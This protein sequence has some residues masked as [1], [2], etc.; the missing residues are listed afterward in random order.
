MTK[1][2]PKAFFDLETLEK[3]GIDPN[4]AAPVSSVT[5]NAHPKTENKERS[6]L[7][8]SKASLKQPLQENPNTEIINQKQAA[9]KKNKELLELLCKRFPRVFNLQ[10]PQPLKIN[11]VEDLCIQLKDEY[12]NEQ[13]RKAIGYYTYNVR[14]QSALLAHDHR[15]DLEGKV[16]GEVTPEHKERAKTQLS[17]LKNS[18]KSKDRM[19]FSKNKE[20]LMEKKS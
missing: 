16:N 5:D 15:Y 10:I 12:T 4:Q 14:Y 6:N 19:S 18:S 3:L 20:F 8:K 7:L 17:K 13:I 11:I 1:S 9:V 2:P